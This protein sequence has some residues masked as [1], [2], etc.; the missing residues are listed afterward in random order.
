MYYSNSGFCYTTCA[1]CVT[2]FS[3]GGKFRLV[4]NFTE[5][6]IFTLGSKPPAL[7]H[8]CMYEVMS[9]GHHSGFTVT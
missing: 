2:I 8:L 3:T 4:S 6:Y 5:L 1:V 9:G 7:T